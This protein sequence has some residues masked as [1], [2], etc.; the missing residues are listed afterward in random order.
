MGVCTEL[1][2]KLKVDFYQVVQMG[3]II[4][5]TSKYLCRIKEAYLDSKLLHLLPFS[6]N[7]PTQT[8]YKNI[9]R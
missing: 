5:H 8:R 1:V 3:V 7:A 6:S 2:P 4:A 9:F